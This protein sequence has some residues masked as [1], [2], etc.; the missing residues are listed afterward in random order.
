MILLQLV[1]QLFIIESLFPI[2][3]TSI[4]S[5]VSICFMRNCAIISFMFVG[6][7]NEL[8]SLSIAHNK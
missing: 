1:I 4:I 8:E 3:I 6:R 2:L 5:S 7:K